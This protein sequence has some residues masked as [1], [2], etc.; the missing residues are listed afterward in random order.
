MGGKGEG[1]FNGA[2]T[3]TSPYICP[4]GN[5]F[6]SLDSRPLSVEYSERSGRQMQ[7]RVGRS[8]REKTKAEL[9]HTVTYNEAGS[10]TREG[11]LIYQRKAKA[12]SKL[13]FN[14]I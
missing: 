6:F 1:I 8:L 9:S 2:T 11:L 12:L 10:E 13:V 4:V 3:K 7:N 5:P 14:S